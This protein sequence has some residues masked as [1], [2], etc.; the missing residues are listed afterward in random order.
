MIWQRLS[1]GAGTTSPVVAEGNAH[2]QLGVESE[3]SQKLKL[4]V[5]AD[6]LKML[7]Q[8]LALQCPGF[9]YRFRFRVSAYC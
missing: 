4:L 6:F 7:L 3:E 9:I 2:S 8:H 1:T 5:Y